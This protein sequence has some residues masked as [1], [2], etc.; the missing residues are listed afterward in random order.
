MLSSKA[1]IDGCLELRLCREQTRHRREKPCREIFSLAAENVGEERRSSRKCTG[2]KRYYRYDIA[3]VDTAFEYGPF[4]ESIRATGSKVDLFDFRF[5]T[6]PID[7]ETGLVVYQLRYYNPQTGRWLN[8]DPIGE[9][10][11]L[12][13]YGMVNNDTIN[14]VDVHGLRGFRPPVPPA[15]RRPGRYFP[16]PPERN[17][18]TPPNPSQ[19]PTGLPGTIGPALELLDETRSFL[20]RFNEGTSG[21]SGAYRLA[22]ARE[23]FAAFCDEA[24]REAGSPPEGCGCCV[25][26][27]ILTWNDPIMV[28]PTW[29][30]PNGYAD[31]QGN[32]V[33]R[34]N[35]DVKYTQ[36]K[37]SEVDPY[38]LFGASLIDPYYMQI[39][40]WDMEK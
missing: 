13:L 37:C 9:D 1:I 31:R 10:G 35:I 30:N 39:R 7:Q 17:L 16:P 29:L 33:I 19:S 6:K 38:V 4:G 14:Y 25:M 27:A 3:L 15:N 32:F 34:A 21:Q 23:N 12:N 24:W 8:K 22:R 26:Q 36:S 5:S 40:Y 11:G 2:G 18:N 28:R 20:E